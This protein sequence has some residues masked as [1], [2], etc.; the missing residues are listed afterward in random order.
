MAPIFKGDDIFSDE[1][2]FEMKPPRSSCI[3][4]FLRKNAFSNDSISRRFY[5]D[6]SQ[7]QKFMVK[8]FIWK[9]FKN[10]T[11]VWM[12]KKVARKHMA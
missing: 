10:L 9:S 12:E 1:L 3:I 8:N 11:C 6:S 5:I 4:K 2:L 7:S